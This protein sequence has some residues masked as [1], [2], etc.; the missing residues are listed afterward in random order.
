MVLSAPQGQGAQEGLPL[1]R[2]AAVVDND[3]VTQTELDR[4]L[5][6]VMRKLSARPGLMPPAEL[7]RRQVLERMVLER[8]QLQMAERRGIRIDDLT[9]NE[10]MRKIARRNNLS[11]QEFRDRLVNSGIDYAEFREQV[12]NEVIIDKLQERVI[13]RKVRVSDQE[14]ED[15]IASQSGALNS[16]VEYR[17]GHILIA[18]PEGATPDEVKAA[19]DKAMAI[20]ERLLEGEDF[21][22]LAASESDG[23]KAL[24]GGDLGWRKANQLPSIF[25]RDITKL[26]V[27]DISEPIRSPSGFHIIKL[28]DRRGQTSQVIQQTHA[29]HI[30][31]KTSAVV[32]DDQ[33]RTQ[34]NSLRQRLLNGTDFAELAR[35][36]SDDAA[37]AVDGGDLG[38]SNPGE[39]VPEFEEVMGSLQPGQISEPFR[40]PYGWHI[41]EVLGRRDYDGT[42]EVLRAQARQILR[43]RK[44]EEQTELWERRLRDESYVEY[45]L[46]QDSAQE[47]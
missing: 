3:V 41:V 2:I 18:L 14:I 24:E 34:L 27:G 28:Q 16:D 42:E 6:A 15:F 38:W 8:L 40:S 26:D 29:R 12:R 10:T 22:Q 1:D 31:I 44:I 20:R 43:A 39:L 4:R 19:R 37:S 5:R 47:G 32:D 9:L 23:Q 7:L 33:A 46:D 45:R 35:S 13:D 21:A 36:N 30:L 17:I 11:L 25:A